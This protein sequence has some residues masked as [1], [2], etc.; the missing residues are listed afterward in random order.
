MISFQCSEYVMSFER[1]TN[2]NNYKNKN[3]ITIS[4]LRLGAVEFG[5]KGDV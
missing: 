3:N 5:P 1:A 4:H 2:Q